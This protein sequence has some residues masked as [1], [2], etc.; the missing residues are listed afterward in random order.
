ME[1]CSPVI[2]VQGRINGEAV[3]EVRVGQVDAAVA[4][5]VCVVLLQGLNPGLP[6][7]A[8]GCNEGPLVRMPEHLRKQPCLG[9]PATVQ[10]SIS[11]E[12]A[13]VAQHESSS[14]C[15]LPGLIVSKVG[16]NTCAPCRTDRAG[17]IHSI[18]TDICHVC[19]LRVDNSITDISARTY[20]C[21]WAG[22]SSAQ[23]GA[24]W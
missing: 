11:L 5:E 2:L 13:G 20:S 9:G 3:H 19:T 15:E 23:H 1:K 18:H 21:H 17:G 22:L 24:H 4:D 8:A 14:T 16:T 10:K 6:G 7:V 12:T